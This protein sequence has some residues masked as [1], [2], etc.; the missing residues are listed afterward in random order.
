MHAFALEFCFTPSEIA[1]QTQVLEAL[2]QHFQLASTPI[3]WPTEI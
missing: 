1:Y 2:E 3:R